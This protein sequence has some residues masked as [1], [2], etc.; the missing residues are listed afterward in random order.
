VQGSEAL[1][2]V[3]LSILVGS[4]RSKVPLECP[5][6]MVAKLHLGSISPLGGSTVD[7][8]EPHPNSL[9]SHMKCFNRIR[10][11]LAISTAVATACTTVLP[12]PS[13][14]PG[15]DGGFTPL[16]GGRDA[17]DDDAGASLEE[18]CSTGNLWHFDGQ[19]CLEI[20]DESDAGTSF[21]G[22]VTCIRA[23]V[24]DGACNEDKI[25]FLY[26]GRT[27]DQCERF[28]TCAPPADEDITSCVL[29]QLQV[30]CDSARAAGDCP[31]SG[32]TC[33]LFNSKS[34]E[35]T[36]KRL[37]AGSLLESIEFFFC[38]MR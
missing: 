27:Y 6:L 17:G 31:I 23:N 19:H 35:L 29:F 34:R 16:D 38:T 37:C 25:K 4:L 2:W 36:H 14:R 12:E 15:P 13:P 10:L 20:R 5:I 32:L 9:V 28:R 21:P 7:P 24:A 11:A 3:N 33:D 26:P 30:P 18:P 8:K 22:P 1:S